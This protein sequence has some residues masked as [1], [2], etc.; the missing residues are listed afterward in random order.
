MVVTIQFSG[1]IKNSFTISALTASD[2]VIIIS[3]SFNR[4]RVTTRNA[5]VADYFLSTAS[6]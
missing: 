4:S 3:A 5:G 6:G 1:E 2:G